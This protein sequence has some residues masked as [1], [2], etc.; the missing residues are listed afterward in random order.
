MSATALSGGCH[1]G[2]IRFAIADADVLGTGYCHCSI[3]QRLSGG[4]VN[5]WV[6]IAPVALRVSGSV[7]HYRSSPQGQRGFCSDCGSQLW[8]APDDASYIT[9]NATSFDD[10]E[11]EA[12]RPALHIFDSDRL[13][14]F[15][16]ADTLPRFPQSL[17]SDAE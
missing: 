17:P 12:L 2:A 16:V 10:A 8:Y 15:D 7:K 9:L 6:A 1:C 5:A 11:A 4:P 13:C 3:C 14:W